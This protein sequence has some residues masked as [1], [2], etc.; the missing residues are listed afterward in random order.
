MDGYRVLDADAPPPGAGTAG[1]LA[2]DALGVGLTRA[3][4][5]PRPDTGFSGP[6]DLPGPLHPSAPGGDPLPSAESPVPGDGF[7]RGIAGGAGATDTQDPLTAAM[8][9]GLWRG[10]LGYYLSQMSPRTGARTRAAS[11]AATRWRR[12]PTSANSTASAAR[13]RTGRRRSAP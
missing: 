6:R 4:S 1:R 9:E 13:W 2:T 10:T 12:T 5:L 7:R 8:H 3:A 11:T